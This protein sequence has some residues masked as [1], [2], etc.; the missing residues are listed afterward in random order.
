MIS[1]PYIKTLTDDQ[2]LQ[3]ILKIIRGNKE[4]KS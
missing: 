1:F 3:Y 4:M 2:V